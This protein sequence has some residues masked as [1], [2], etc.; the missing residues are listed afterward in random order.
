MFPIIDILTVANVVIGHREVI[1]VTTAQVVQY[2][3]TWVEGV[4]RG[5]EVRH[6][7]RAPKYNERK[8]ITKNIVLKP[9][10]IHLYVTCSCCYEH[11]SQNFFWESHQRPWLHG[12]AFILLHVHFPIEND[13]ENANI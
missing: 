12:Y 11:L 7:N 10:N 9:S 3:L 4:S 6:Q 1:S 2:Y 8:T 13:H 5:M